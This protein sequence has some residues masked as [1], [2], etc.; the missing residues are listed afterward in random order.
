MGQNFCCAN[1]TDYTS[2]MQKQT[3]PKIIFAEEPQTT[4]PFKEY[5]LTQGCRDSNAGQNYT[6]LNLTKYESTRFT[7]GMKGG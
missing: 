4:T 3:Q 5:Q 7:I 6:F 1:S 2:T